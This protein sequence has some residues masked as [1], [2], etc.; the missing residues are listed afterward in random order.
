MRRCGLAGLALALLLGGGLRAEDKKGDKGAAVK[1]EYKRLNGTWELVRAVDDGKELPAPKVKTTVTFKDGKY[2]AR[3]GGKVVAE[4]TAKLDPTTSPKAVDTTPAT[5]ADKGKTSR[6]IYEVKGDTQRVCFA[7][8]GQ[9]RPKT[10][11]AKEGS[12]HG[13]ATYKRVKP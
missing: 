2:T 10:F 8:P 6:G 5:G 3:Q 11:G 4:G 7:R 12:G 13:L 1:E 9:P